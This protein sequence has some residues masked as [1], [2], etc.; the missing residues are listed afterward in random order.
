MNDKEKLEKLHRIVYQEQVGW[1]TP[2]VLID[3]IKRE[4][5]GEKQ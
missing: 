1:A 2:R 4:V 3:T 5:F